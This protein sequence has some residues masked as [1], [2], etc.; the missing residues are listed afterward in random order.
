MFACNMLGALDV[1]VP[2]KTPC[3][4]R[5]GSHMNIHSGPRGDPEAAGYKAGNPL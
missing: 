5:G 3:Y 4:Y 1:H 2:E